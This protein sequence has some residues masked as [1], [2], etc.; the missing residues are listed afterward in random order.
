VFVSIVI[1]TRNRSVLL[2]QALRALARQTWRA[3]DLE[4]IVA[5]NGSTDDTRD[6]VRSNEASGC[7]VRY[8]SV[9]EPGKSHAVNAALRIARGDVIAF[10]DDDVQP[11][12]SWIANLARAFDETGVDF[13]AGRIQPIWEVAPPQWMSPALHGVLAVPDNGDVR[14]PIGEGETNQV[15]PIGANTAIRA[16]VLARIGGLRTDLG[17]L[18]GSLRTGED[19]EL[20]LRL[21]HHGYRGVYEP[22]ALVAH[23]VP[24]SRLRR[25]YFRRWLYQNGGDVARIERRYPP[26]VAYRLGV[27]RYLWLEAVTDLVSTAR[28]TF[29]GD[30]RRRFAKSLRLLWFA[31]YLGETWFGAARAP[32]PAALVPAAPQ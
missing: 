29:L 4:I 31:G 3:D 2:G 23:F 13:V 15:M 9:P 30:A 27:P 16:S 19:H 21:I 1:A 12:R 11:E 6:V 25:S 28:A 10:T 14:L 7:A 24:A 26:A 20:F 5:D 32:E 18:N 17:K 8:L 22:A